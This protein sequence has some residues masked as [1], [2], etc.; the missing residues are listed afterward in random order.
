M[1]TPEIAR[2]ALAFLGTYALHSTL[3]LAA[4][5]ALCVSRPSLAPRMRERLW[6]LGLVGGLLTA[7]AQLLLGTQPLLGSIVLRPETPAT[8]PDPAPRRP[9]ATPLPEPESSTAPAA[10]RKR[11]SE[12]RPDSRPHRIRPTP[13]GTEPSVEPALARSEPA[14]IDLIQPALGRADSEIIPASSIAPPP[15]RA[16]ESARAPRDGARPAPWS[17]MRALAQRVT[18]GSSWA[19]WV[20]LGWAVAGGTLVLGLLTSWTLFR[21]RL[22]R[23]R[24]L[25]DG[26]LVQKVE[27]LRR[28]AGLSARVRLSVCDRISSPISLGLFRPEICIPSAVLSELTPPQQETLLAHEIAHHKRG[29]PAW[30]ALYCLLEK[31][32]FFQPLN[33]LARRSLQE[34]AEQSCD[35]WAVRWTGERLALASCLTEVAQWIVGARSRELAF[36]GLSSNRSKL[37]E[38]VERLLDDRRS[39]AV[40]PGARFGLPLFLGVAGLFVLA[41]PGIS[42]SA[43]R[44]IPSPLAPPPP[45][46]LLPRSSEQ[47]PAAAASVAEPPAAPPAPAPVEPAAEAPVEGSRAGVAGDHELLEEEMHLLE[48]EFDELKHELA[49]SELHER[50]S[51]ELGLIEQ[52]MTELRARRERVGALL[53]RLTSQETASD[54]K[55]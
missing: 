7:C 36:P 3:L 47:E 43:E 14:R 41:V 25:T 55:H 44:E 15:P 42:A 33:R 18:K 21:R 51:K 13:L 20:G 29:D 1:T 30:F 19:T 22:V 35:D 5:W 2:S 40:D 23:R 27:E 37:G 11:A 46:A 24:R 32:F 48:T 39:P 34:I 31:L 16:R 10:P 9:S 50:F 54:P 17:S 4:V 45:E 26:L 53:E 38:R 8:A 49:R 52:R 6:R 28:R 12:N